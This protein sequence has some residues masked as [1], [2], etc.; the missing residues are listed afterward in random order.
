LTLARSTYKWGYNVT[1][2]YANG[3]VPTTISKPF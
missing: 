3:E 1:T 2:V